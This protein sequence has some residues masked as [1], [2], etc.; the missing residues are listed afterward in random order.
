[1]NLRDGAQVWEVYGGGQ[2]GLVIN[3]PSIQMYINE[4]A[5]KQGLDIN[6]EDGMKQWKAG[7]T[8]GG[9]YDATNHETSFASHTNLKQSKFYRLNPYTNLENP[10]VTP[11]A[12]F[13][14]KRFNTNVIIN[15]G[16]YVGNY[17]YGGGLGHNDRV[18]SGN[19]Y[20]TTYIAL[21]G[22]EVKKDIY[23]AGST[24]TVFD[25]FGVG[26]ESSSNTIYGGFTAGTTAYV[27]GGTCRN[28][29]G[30]GWEGNVGLVA[31]AIKD[32]IP[33]E[34]NVVIGIRPELLRAKTNEETKDDYTKY[35]FHNG[36]PAIQ[37]NAYAG[38][39]G[40]SV[41]GTANITVNNGY[42]GYAYVA[43]DEVLNDSGMVKL[44][45][46]LDASEEHLKPATADRI[47]RYEKLIHDESYWEG[48]DWKGTNRLI[49]C[50]NVFGSGYDDLSSVD[51]S[52][53]TLYG[54]TIR[55]S[56]FGGGEIATI[57]RGSND[58]NDNKVS[59]KKAGETHIYMYNGK[60]LRNVFGAGKGYNSL[61]YGGAHKLYTDG[62][63]FGKTEVN[64][65]GGEIG[66]NKGI[67]AGDGNVFGGGDRGY[68]FSAYEYLVNTDNN[69]VPTTGRGVKKGVRYDHDKDGYYYKE[70][71]LS[72]MT[73]DCKV[74]IEPWLQVKPGQ[75]VTYENKTYNA[76]DYVPT[77]YLN[78]L[79]KKGSTGWTGDWQK[80]DVGQL[81]DEVDDNGHI[82]Y[83]SQNST[84]PKQVFEE[85]GVIIHNA[86]FAGGNVSSNSSMNAN[87]ST[88]LGNAT[89][90]IHDVYHRDLITIGMG[91]TGGLYGDGN[92]TLV[93]GYRELNITNYGTD[94]YH[95]KDD[96]ITITQYRLLPGREQDYYELRYR[97]LQTCT[98]NKGTTYNSG[99]TLRQDDLIELF[100]GQTNIVSSDGTP[101][102]AYWVENGIVSR[103]AGRILNTIQRADF[104]GVFGSRLVLQGA[105]DRVPEV[106]DYNNYTIN[107]VREVSLNKMISTA[108]DA[109]TTD[110]Y[111][112]GNY[113]GIYNVVNY[114]GALT[115]DVDFGDENPNTQVNGQ[116]K[117]DIRTSD[118]SE[119]AI[120]QAA[121]DGIQN[122]RYG[123]QE[124]TFYN[125]KRKHHTD[126]T[127]N[128]GNSHNQVALASGVYLELTTEESTGPSFEE[129]VWGP[130][131]GVVE[132]DLINVSTGTGG[133]FVYAKNEH[134]IRKD[135]T[136]NN[137]LTAMNQNAVSYKDFDYYTDDDHKREWQTSGNFVHSTQTIIDDCYNIGG[138]YKGS[139]AVAG[140]YWFI[141]GQVY[142]YDQIISAYTG[143]PNAYSE[144]VD[145]PLT[146]T[147]ASRG[148]MTLIDV[149]P[150]LYAYYKEYT[151]ATNNTKLGADEKIV[152]RDVA[153]QLNDPISYWDW[154]QLREADQALFVP[155]TYYVL[156]DCK[157]GNTPY[158]AGTVM[159]KKDYDDLSTSGE[160]SGK[161]AV[162]QEKKVGEETQTVD[163]DFDYVF[164]PT[165]NLGHDTGYILT[166][167]MTNPSTWDKWYTEKVSASAAQQTTKQYNKLN[168]TT[169]GTTLGKDAYWDGPT[170]R[171]KSGTAAVLA[172]QTSY[173]LA[174]II[175]QADFDAYEGD[176]D[177]NHNNTLDTGE[178]KNGNGVLDKGI[179]KKYP[180]AI[181]TDDPNATG[182]DKDKV[183]AIFERAYLTTQYVETQKKNPNGSEP[184][185]V[186]IHLQE[187]AKL[188]ASEY[189][190]GTWSSLTNSGKVA[191]AFVCNKSFDYI[192]GN[193]ITVG[194]LMTRADIDNLESNINTSIA[195][196]AKEKIADLT[197]EQYN[198]IKGN[199]TLT[200]AQQIALGTDGNMTLS[201]MTAMKDNISANFVPAYYCT[202]EG[203]YGGDYYEQG[204]NY[205]GL[206]A[207]SAMSDGDRGKFE[208]NYDALD[209]FIDPDYSGDLAMKYQYDGTVD[210]NEDNVITAVDVKNPPE[211]SLPTAVDYSATYEG[212]EMTGDTKLSQKV[213]VTRVINNVS[214][215]LDGDNK[216]DQLK[217]GDILDREEFEK[218]FNEQYHYAPIS[219]TSTDL[220][221]TFYIVNTAF[222][223]D[224]PYAVGQVI[225]K[226]TYDNLDGTAATA[227]T[228]ATGEKAN[229]TLLT[230][231]EAGTYYYCRDAYTIDE[232]YGQSVEAVMDNSK[233]YDSDGNL[234][235]TPVKVH[236][237]RGKSEEVPVGFVIKQGT[238]IDFENCY[239]SLVNEQTNF[240]I[241]GV[242]PVETSTLYVSKNSDIFDLA[243]DKIITVIYQYDYEESDQSG[244][245]ITPVSERHVVNIRIKFK[246]GIPTVG[247]IDAPGIVL[248]GTNVILTAPE[249]TPGAYQV[250]GGGWELFATEAEA[251]S[252]INGIEYTPE[253]DPLYWYQDGYLVAYYAKTY[254]G[255]TYSKN[256]VPVSVANYH[257][258]HEV[259]EDMTHHLHVD[260]PNVKRNSKIYIHD[261]SGS[262][263]DGAELLKDFF[264]LS[265]LTESYVTVDQQGLIT[266]IKNETDATK[267]DRFNG[268][269]LLDTHVKAGKHLDF[270]LHSN[271]NHDP[272][273][274]WTPIAGEKNTLT[275]QYINCFEG[276]LHGDG[277]TISGLSES[278]FGKLCGDIYNLGVTGTFIGAGIAEEGEGYI[279][280]GWIS[281]T[282]TAAKTSRPVFGNPNRT[283]DSRGLVQVVNS[284]YL[285]NDAD[286]YEAGTTTPKTG[287]YTKK[288]ADANDDNHG[289]PTRKPAKAFYNGEVAYD[290][291]S[292]YLN[293]R[294]YDQQTLS[295]SERGSYKYLERGTDGK[296]KKDPIDGYY[297]STRSTYVKYSDLGYVEDRYD[298]GDFRYSEG[299]IPTSAEQRERIIEKYQQTTD[300]T[301]NQTTT[302]TTQ[303]TIY[304]P[305]W[306]DDYLFFGQN[307]TYGHDE[308]RPHQDEPSHFLGEN[309]V[310]RAPA[311]Y[312]NSTMSV[313]HFNPDAVLAAKENPATVAADKTPREAY[314]GMTAIDFAGHNDLS[315]GYKQGLNG[316]WFYQPLLD[317]DGLTSI[318]N[319]DETRNLLVYAPAG[320]GDG[321]TN[322]TTL[323]ALTSYFIDPDYVVNS[324]ANE[325]S[326][327]R[328]FTDTKKYGR[329][330][331]IPE[332]DIHGH[333]VQSDF[334]ATTDH[335][336]VDKNDFNAPFGY[337]FADDKRM[338]YQ[339]TPDDYANLN[340]G[341]EGVSIPFEAE[342][343]TTNEKG[344][345]THFYKEDATSQFSKKYDTGH[346]YWLRKFESLGQ[347]TDAQTNETMLAATFKA[348]VKMSAITKKDDNIFLWDYYY[349]YNQ[350]KD[351]NEDVY[352]SYDDEDYKKTEYYKYE[353]S[354]PGY[355]RLT[356]ATPYIIGFPGEQYYEFDL[357]GKFSPTTAHATIP[358]LL[359]QQTISF[360]SL[361]GISIGKSDDEKAGISK[362]V[363]IDNK[364]YDFTFWPSYL[365]EELADDGN[366]ALNNDGNAY[367]KLDNTAVTYNT[368]GA[369]YANEEAFNAA[370]TAAGG[371]LYSDA[372]GTV[373][374]ESWTEGT[375]YYKRTSVKTTK[376]DVNNVTPLLS[377]FRPYFTGSVTNSA[378]RRIIIVGD[379]NTSL[380]PDIDE[381]HS[382]YIDGGLIISVDKRN[383][384][385][386]STL[387]ENAKVRITTTTGLDVATFSIE[388]GQIVRT[389]V[390][391]TGVYIV[392]RH[393]L[394]VK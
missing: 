177:T 111:L 262:S 305:I 313:A 355:P 97:C 361:P 383:I 77:S 271:I 207:W 282:S 237:T 132:L 224:E 251:E 259:L 295:E 171:L 135:G 327:T 104:C 29:Y 255:K 103:Y 28:V 168:P 265:L 325:D 346:E 390:N 47:E 286:A 181:P 302:I 85:R 309:R 134:G 13:G 375:T 248:P 184:E 276:T 312:R 151:N 311:Y 217:P 319:A 268:H 379:N 8:L 32:E 22:G 154:Q 157:I 121:I 120:Y 161:P 4:F 26:A 25:L 350:S 206:A 317:D 330:A 348:P 388:P 55:N 360:V 140:H 165:N 147:A 95:L 11:R 236:D 94:Y 174:D 66:T 353:R 116:W 162:T 263:K 345:I 380:Q 33:G 91:H 231:S 283:T 131:T 291:N 27:E 382:G 339:R 20:G 334:T 370:V 281:T 48:S 193:I 381:H 73:E 384:V 356:K 44:I 218:L 194:Q 239:R 391:M 86:V 17:A 105:Q 186:D 368:T 98:D 210:T 113:F 100:A 212:T 81:V 220:N 59:I 300:P 324:D 72:Q 18:Q 51:I 266:G 150:N 163:V 57:G 65:Y 244:L 289:T 185:E 366:Y 109:S 243:Q 372:D 228:S 303:E 64:I 257:D 15:K 130:I 284:Y 258:L 123:E 386:E 277:Y 279:E 122:G 211:Y 124:Y 167:S 393:K 341:W 272:T 83:E 5:D 187:G 252:H 288:T 37:R 269:A 357:S 256:H 56:L 197:D 180:G 333:I 6:T 229:V 298:D 278:L 41:I 323:G 49:E 139:D 144:T 287:S 233:C 337:Q 242:A 304:A 343:V 96:Q 285:E 203:L 107:R 138:K 365:N 62:Y 14:G 142:V 219:V 374:A 364:K 75:S 68:V 53:V 387:N 114:L 117:Y 129:K 385:V 235:T 292:F 223:H 136:T 74:L 115:S 126:K 274:P 200:E 143:A 221:K 215:L 24:G 101:N 336:L 315:T 119:T 43:K 90:S 188:A 172:G 19:V 60:V 358:S 110:E 306:P 45:T 264:D 30:G 320:S 192:G 108:G 245:N 342:I 166:Y 249:V 182:Y 173:K 310:Y 169:S 92:L 31:D 7:W 112:H 297:P 54:G 335:L 296:L 273:K 160:N 159:L 332:S 16:A 125:W 250:F 261:H 23:A 234:L 331:A 79:P 238:E 40:G 12:E 164:R 275:N 340:T 201:S 377:A 362:D 78:T 392:N 102:A 146:I 308:N 326:N 21:L 71:N 175:T 290:L 369:T 240:T 246:S 225:E 36:V 322:A 260:N 1:M 191:E 299:S 158:T 3:A 270:I 389:P 42:I 69:D 50:G 213:A 176:E 214:T 338:W 58:N 367:T 301:T 205:R 127:R 183:Q 137:T 371:Q 63:V 209:L 394:L 34:T 152:I 352:K 314:P 106:L 149:Q 208:F 232:T 316:K 247:A 349:S 9:G 354:Y 378:P 145:I 190:D 329:V 307:L 198:A 280:N 196:L 241:H 227:N 204:H 189:K 199:G 61:G 376:N 84:Q 52:K 118:H 230:F 267:R 39:E 93:D 359:S 89:A 179:A 70:N 148:K 35:L 226:S 128:N 222:T 216:V 38:G 318:M 328:K 87:T 156:E 155:E 178:D 133:G 99:S 153:Y 344:E 2:D 202:R 141:K 347:T 195:D 46:K 293:K 67:A 88:V 294:Y 80:L 373:P 253:T 363:T 351:Q 321:Y 10:L 254:L 170:Y 76:G 82:V